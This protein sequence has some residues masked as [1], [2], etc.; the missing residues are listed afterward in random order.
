[1]VPAEAARLVPVRAAASVVAP[2]AAPARAAASV[3]VPAGAPARAAASVVV[4]A[5]PVAASVVVP[6]AERQ[7]APV[8]VP[9]VVVDAVAVR[10]ARSDDPAAGPPGDGSRRSSGV[11]SSTTCRPRR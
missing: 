1:V 9:A 3:V 11:R 2:P 8:D 7:R 6:A 4:P 5:A 10:R